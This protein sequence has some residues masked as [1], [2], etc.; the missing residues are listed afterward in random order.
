MIASARGIADVTAN[1]ITHGK[2]KA[3]LR[4]ML[5][6]RLSG[7]QADQV[8]FL[9]ILHDLLPWDD[10][11]AGISVDALSSVLQGLGFSRGRRGLQRDLKALHEAAWIEYED[12]HS[13]RLWKRLY[14]QPVCAAIDP[15]LAE[16]LNHEAST[17]APGV[18]Q[19]R[20]S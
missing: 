11:A 4:D 20:G 7:G 17:Q 5:A 15:A 6:T 12:F 13:G 18:I 16:L 14:R 3:E 19:R 10:E 2:T 9:A 8:F 1:E